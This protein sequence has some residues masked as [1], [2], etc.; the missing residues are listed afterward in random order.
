MRER[1]THAYG[2]DACIDWCR[3]RRQN[4]RCAVEIFVTRRQNDWNP[5]ATRPASISETTDGGGERSAARSVRYVPPRRARS[6]GPPARGTGVASGA[7][8]RRSGGTCGRRPRS[9]PW[10]S[11]PGRETFDDFDT[12][13]SA[14]V[15]DLF[16]TCSMLTDVFR[17][18]DTRDAF[19]T[20]TE[21][22]SPSLCSMLPDSLIGRLVPVDHCSSRCFE[23]PPVQQFTHY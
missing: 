15:R 20:R 12:N 13:W 18:H 23:A 7:G 11:H 8:R 10:Q 4:T 5:A 1:G 9:A 19:Y 21:Y 6:V 3:P 16:S 14:C 17:Y 2:A 22:R